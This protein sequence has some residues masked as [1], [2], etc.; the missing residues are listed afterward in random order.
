MSKKDITKV[1]VTVEDLMKDDSNW[2]AFDNLSDEEG[3]ILA[4]NDPDAPPTSVIELQKFQRVDDEI[5]LIS[6]RRATRHEVKDY[7]G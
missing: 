3:L 2:E 7:E 4:W 5:R 6:A 1:K